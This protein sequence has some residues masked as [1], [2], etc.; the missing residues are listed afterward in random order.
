MTKSLA[1]QDTRPAHLMV[2]QDQ[3]DLGIEN[4]GIHIVPPRLKVVQPTSKGVY[5]E[6]FAPGDIVLTPQQLLVT[7]LLFDEESKRPMGHS[8]EVL[9]TPL[10]FFPE[11]CVWNPLDR[12]SLPMIREQSLD[13][14]SAIAI[15]ARDFKS[16]SAPCP[17]M[18]DKFI[19][20]VEHLNFVVM[21]HSE[22]LTMPLVM[23]FSKAEHKVGSNF[24]TMLQM[25]RTAIYGCQFVFRSQYR[26][27]PKGRWYGIDIDQPPVALGSWVTDPDQFERNKQQYLRLKEAHADK[28]L[29][30][31]HSDDASEILGEVV[32]S[33]MV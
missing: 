25:R 21:I 7:R 29:V 22:E 30:V 20:Y 24:M 2:A 12:G 28:A 11:Y 33:D 26:E 3:G 5:A 15:K 9:F 4:M 10:F 18:P 1:I 23:S 13:P 19:T 14:K 8:P 17:E 6:K 27:S 16:R 31:D 32:N